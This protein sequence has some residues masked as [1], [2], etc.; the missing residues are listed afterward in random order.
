MKLN[1]AIRSHRERQNLSQQDLAE[2]AHLSL[3]YISKIELGKVKNVGVVTLGRIAK[4]LGCRL[5]VSL[6][7]QK[8]A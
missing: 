8:A 1:E 2:G 7:N 3:D 6:E 5:V 4:A